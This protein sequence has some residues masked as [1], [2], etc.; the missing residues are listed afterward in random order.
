LWIAALIRLQQWYVLP[1]LPECRGQSYNVTTTGFEVGNVKGRCM[2]I[3]ALSVSIIMA[4]G[5]N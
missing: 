2:Y 1:K 3:H 5:T 4:L